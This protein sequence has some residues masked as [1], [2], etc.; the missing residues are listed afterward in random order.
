MENI[1]LKAIITGATGMVGEGVMHE[2][3]QHPDVESVLLINRKPSG[4]TNPK[5]QEVIVPD[6]FNLSAI[7]SHLN[8]YNACFF[9]AGISSVG[10]KEPEFT[11]IAYD[12][13]MNVA[14]TL[15]KLNPGMTF[16]YISGAG[17]DSTE[18]G[19]MMWARVKA[20]TENDLA[21]LP[22][23]AAFAL[24]PPFM[25]PTKG[26]KN[27]LPYYK[28]VTWMYPLA[29]PLFPGYFITL[30]ELGLAMINSVLYGFD[31]KILEAKDISGLAVKTGR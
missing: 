23:K 2:C 3:L 20:K 12:L 28:Y 13:T 9:C 17:T 24:R 16:C 4:F 7:E 22:F 10:V 21:K 19:K 1:K 6:F 25:L 18:K 31:K 29:R 14:R 26:L 27:T 30:K 8:G 5:L 11:R 15:V